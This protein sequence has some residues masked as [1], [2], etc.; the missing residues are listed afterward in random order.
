M[1][2]KYYGLVTSEINTYLRVSIIRKYVSHSYLLIN[3]IIQKT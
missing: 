1:G 3:W 2:L